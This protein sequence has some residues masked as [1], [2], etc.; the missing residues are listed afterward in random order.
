MSLGDGIARA[1]REAANDG[2]TSPPAKK[3]TD[4]L[5]H[6]EEPRWERIR[7]RLEHAGIE[8][9]DA[10]IASKHTEDHAL[11]FGILVTRDG[12]VFGFEFDFLRD[13]TGQSIEYEDARVTAWEELDQSSRD[14][15]KR[16]L[17]TGREVLEGEE[18]RGG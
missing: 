8:L 14:L 6:S 5:R 15:Y 12:S 9:E 3:H 2:R 11:E 16:A 17:E 1:E 18:P 10:A 13:E 4:E 7:S